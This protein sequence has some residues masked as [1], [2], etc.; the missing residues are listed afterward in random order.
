M[1]G[2]KLGRRGW[3]MGFLEEENRFLLG[4]LDLRVVIFFFMGRI[5]GFLRL[6]LV[7]LGV[8]LGICLVN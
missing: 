1:V 4:W 8:E 6:W 2:E 3:S 7:V 5:G